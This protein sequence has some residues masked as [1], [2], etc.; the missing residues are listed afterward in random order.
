MIKTTLL[1]TFCLLALSSCYTIQGQIGSGAQSGSVKKAKN[2]FLVYGLAPLETTTPEQ[3]AQ[4]AANYDYKIEQ[5][6][7]DGVIALLTYGIYSP[8]TT[9]VTK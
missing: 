9:T 6:F 4:G 5:S 1:S 7:V 2:H 8:T 3:L